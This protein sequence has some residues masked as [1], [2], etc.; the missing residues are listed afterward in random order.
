MAYK[1]MANDQMATAST[2][3][4]LPRSFG[5]AKVVFAAKGLAELYQ[6]GCAKILL[7]KSYCTIPHAVIINTSGGM[8]G[9]DR[10]EILA[11][12]KDGASLCVTSQTA[13]RLYRSSGGVVK[14]SNSV[15]V[16]D[17]C[18][19]EWLPQE[20][21]LF[22]GSALERKFEVRLGQ[23]S[24]FLASETLVLG[25][26]AMGE[27]LGFATLGDQWRIWQNGEIIYGDAL[28]F[29]PNIGK[30]FSLSGVFAN[31]RV[32]ST[33]LYVAPDA[34]QRCAEARLLLEKAVG[35]L[36]GGDGGDAKVEVAVSA[37]NGMLLARLIGF[38]AEYLRQVLIKYLQGFRGQDMPR[39]WHM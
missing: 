38:E 39:V 21:I 35:S 6:S 1:N 37:W 4:A 20:T 34:E 32:L 2:K 26:A 30:S 28:R 15:I 23:R 8:T 27:T 14:I 33:L 7:P 12:V 31:H 10:F 9:G 25:R 36:A 5:M 18:A 22:D 13:E 3:V 29:G 17:D 16:G 11:E 24:S 19:F